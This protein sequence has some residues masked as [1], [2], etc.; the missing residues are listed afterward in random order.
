[1]SPATW[2]PSVPADSRRGQGRWFHV[3]VGGDG[4]MVT[5][6]A[7]IPGDV[8]SDGR[9]DWKDLGDLGANWGK[10]YDI[11]SGVLPFDLN[12]DGSVDVLDLV[13]LSGFWLVDNN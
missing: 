3:A 1:M 7:P 9:L 11:A 2:Q 5:L 13:N 8:V 12:A 10:T 4:K 6:A